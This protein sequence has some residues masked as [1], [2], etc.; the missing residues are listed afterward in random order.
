MQGWGPYQVVSALLVNIAKASSVRLVSPFG[1]T[2]QR[3]HQGDW[4][5]CLQALADFKERIRK[6]EEAYDT[7]TDRKLHFIK[8]TDM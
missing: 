7:I 8:L 2:L 5:I 3:H 1:Q 4:S 6:Y